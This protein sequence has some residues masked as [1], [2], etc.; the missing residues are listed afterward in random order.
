MDRN[1]QILGI[2][3]KAG[4]LA[5]G[6]DAVSTAA[7]NGKAKLIISASDASDGTCRRA[8]INAKAGFCIHII[9]PF[10]KYE[11]G[12]VSLRGSP[13]TV[14]VLDTGLAA[15]FMKGLAETYPDRYGSEAESLAEEARSL[16]E[17]KRQTAPG[18]R[19]TAQ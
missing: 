13:G 14:A 1:L 16:K 4:L 2:A 19:R 10:T 11:L 8:G 3:K 6:G 17:K 5:V 9:S 12:T 15:R 7:R 18:K